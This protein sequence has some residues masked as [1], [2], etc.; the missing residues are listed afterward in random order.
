MV[1][2]R[3][4]QYASNFFFSTSIVGHFLSML[5]ASGDPV[6]RFLVNH[7]YSLDSPKPPPWFQFI[8]YKVDSLAR[9]ACSH[10]RNN[11]RARA[12]ATVRS[13]FVKL[14]VSFRRAVLFASLFYLRIINASRP[15]ER[16]FLMN[17]NNFSASVSQN[18][19]HS[20]SIA[21]HHSLRVSVCAS[22]Y[23][24]LLDVEKIFFKGWGKN[25][26]QNT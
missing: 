4:I 9:W 5:F 20:M 1:P 14:I 7:G 11:K 19:M 12:R 22:S 17:E 16:V 23:P 3:M 25:F 10:G 13:V 2:S 8:C 15:R 26:W 24:S 6:R 21:R 18:K